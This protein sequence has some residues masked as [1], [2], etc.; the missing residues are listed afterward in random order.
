MKF[1]PSLDSGKEISTNKRQWQARGKKKNTQYQGERQK[2]RSFS[3]ISTYSWQ[4]LAR[5]LEKRIRD[6]LAFG[7]A[8]GGLIPPPHQL[9]PTHYLLKAI[10]G[11]YFSKLAI[12]CNWFLFYHEVTLL[13]FTSVFKANP[14]FFYWIFYFILFYFI[15]KLT[16]FG[17][18]I[19]NFN[20]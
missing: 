3:L 4:W 1:F 9:C 11:M 15:G 12:K 6:F 14:N 2:K 16:G 10:A 5:W 19:E 7:P 8:S 13:L 18:K 17:F 20:F